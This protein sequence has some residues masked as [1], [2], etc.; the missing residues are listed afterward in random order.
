MR[1]TLLT[2]KWSRSQSVLP[3]VV[4]GGPLCT[5]HQKHTLP[6]NFCVQIRVKNKQKQQ[7]NKQA[8]QNKCSKKI[9]NRTFDFKMAAKKHLKFCDINF[10]IKN[11][12]TIL[13]KE[14]FHKIW[15][16]NNKCKYNC[17]AKIKFEKTNI[18]YVLGKNN[19]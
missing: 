8:K 18:G 14:F 13:P 4:K 3:L 6:D 5:Q 9:E 15:L 7:T 19:E 10:P 12:K 2:L 11:L 16:L 1:K 17:I